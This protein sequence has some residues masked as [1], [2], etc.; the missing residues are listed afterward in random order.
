MPKIAWIDGKGRRRITT[1]LSCP[2]C[3]FTAQRR[4]RTST[5]SPVGRAVTHGQPG[6]ASRRS[7]LSMAVEEL[8]ASAQWPVSP[9]ADVSA[10]RTSPTE[11]KASDSEPCYQGESSYRSRAGCPS[12]PRTVTAPRTA[13]L[14]ER[15]LSRRRWP[16]DCSPSARCCSPRPCSGSRWCLCHAQ[17]HGR[18]LTPLAWRLY[19]RPCRCTLFPDATA[20]SA[21]PSR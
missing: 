4:S 16:S 2:A 9:D 19:Q 8:P 15:F 14:T 7:P 12:G 1:G 5:A 6:P 11:Q 10:E 13:S 20:M 18:E 17:P 21:V 3:R